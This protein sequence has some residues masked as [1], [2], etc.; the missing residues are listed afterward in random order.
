[1]HLCAPIS[2][3]AAP[4]HRRRPPPLPCLH[5]P[6][7][8]S[9]AHWPRPLVQNMLVSQGRHTVRVNR[10]VENAETPLFKSKFYQWDPPKSF[11]FTAPRSSGIA[12]VRALLWPRLPAALQ[13][14]PPASCNPALHPGACNHH[15]FASPGSRALQAGRGAAAKPVDVASLHSRASETLV[16][17]GTGTVQVYRIIDV[18]KVRG[19]MVW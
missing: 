3:L 15:H 5:G 13:Y 12:G 2:S 1:M 8:A 7:P 11:D 6:D 16:D 19:R 14:P 9:A 17:D 4:A 10:I 18:T